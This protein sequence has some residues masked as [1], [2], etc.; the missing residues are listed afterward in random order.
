M[1]FL[2]SRFIRAKSENVTCFS[3][4]ALAEDDHKPEGR[5]P[6]DQPRDGNSN[7]SVCL[8]I[9]KVVL[10]GEENTDYNEL[11]FISRP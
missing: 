4:A 10:V 9:G 6:E 1:P 3:R 2:Y 7:A 8:L 5:T 11:K